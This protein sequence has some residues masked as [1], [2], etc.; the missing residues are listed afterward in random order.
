MGHLPIAARGPKV[1][2]VASAS[3]WI[4]GDALRQ[5]DGTAQ[6]PGMVEAVGMPDLHPGKGSPVGAA[7][8]SRGFVRPALVGS[9]IGCGMALWQLDLPLRRLRPERAAALLDG[10]DTP[11]EGDAA[12]W[13]APRAACPPLATRRR[14]ARSGTATTSARCRAC[15]RWPIRPPSAPSVS[16][17][18]GRCC[19]SI[20]A[21]AVS[22]K[23]S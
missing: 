18:S 23:R 4:E 2:V 8:L 13:L 17:R 15:G 16:T 6:L 22:A 10:L 5:L 14:W 20:P 21:A 11:W 12:A 3:T 7:F 19:W 1:R 9:D